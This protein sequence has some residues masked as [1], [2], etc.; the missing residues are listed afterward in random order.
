MASFDPRTV[1]QATAVQPLDL[2]ENAYRISRL[3]AS[4]QEQ[5]INAMKMAEYQRQQQE[6]E[7]QRNALGASVYGPQSA[8]AQMPAQSMG[9][10][11]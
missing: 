9:G 2:T 4:Q 5:Q 7:A 1:F 11:A 10:S 8:S 3:R 6:A